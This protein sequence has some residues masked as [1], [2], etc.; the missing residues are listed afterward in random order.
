MV[1]QDGA[2]VH[3]LKMVHTVPKVLDDCKM[4]CMHAFNFGRESMYFLKSVK[5]LS[6]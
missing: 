1:M 2:S 3:H 5:S 4:M 6:N